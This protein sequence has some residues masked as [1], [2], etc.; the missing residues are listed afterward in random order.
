MILD[1]SN[2]DIEKFSLAKS[3]RSIKLLYDKQPFQI[4]TT[5]LY[6]PFGVKNQSKDWSNF[7]EY[8]IDCS[9]NQSSNENSTNFRNFIDALDKRIVELV[10]NNQN[11]FTNYSQNLQYNTILRANGDYPKLVKFGFPRDKNGNFESVLF[12]QNKK[13]IRINEE[14]IDEILPRG[15]TFKCIIECSKV[16]VFNGK[17]GSMW[18]IAQLKLSDQQKQQ[19]EENTFQKPQIDYSQLLIID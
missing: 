6:S 2:Y 14:S 7:N 16:W 5:T 18:N 10:N 11:L 3:G 8:W 17:I 19:T 15:K 4:C 12:D 13:K 9:L 1:L